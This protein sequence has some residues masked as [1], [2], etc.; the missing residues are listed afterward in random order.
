MSAH[1]TT[2]GAALR[3]AALSER[4]AIHDE[5]LPGNEASLLRVN[6]ERDCL[7]DLPRLADPPERSAGHEVLLSSVTPLK[8]S[9]Q[10]LRGDSSRRKH[11]DPHPKRAELKRRGP[12]EGNQP[13]LA[14][15]VGR[16]RR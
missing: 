1:A 7:R 13:A 9:I 14:G 6:E 15:G 8:T 16:G 3:E 11:I 12:G 4:A 5:L 10:S 2:P